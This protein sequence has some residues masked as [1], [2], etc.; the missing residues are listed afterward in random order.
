MIGRIWIAYRIE[1]IKALHLR[2]VYIGPIL[3]L[4]VV[5]CLPQLHPVARDGYSDY[6]F[7]ARAT[8]M[9]VSLLGL[10]LV[11]TFCAGLVSSEV[12]GGVI[13]S[14]LVRP[15]RRV[16]FLVAKYMLGVTYALLI[17]ISAAATSWAVVAVAGDVAG[18]TYGGE[19]L[20]TNQEMLRDYMLGFLVHLLPL[21]ATVAYAVMI[22]T[23][24][25]NSGVAVGTA[26]AVWAA[27]DATKYPLGIAPFLFTTYF[28]FPWRIFT[29]QARGLEASWQPEIFYCAAA[30]LGAAFLFTGT[31]AAMFNRRDMHL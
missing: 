14:V 10:L 19:V 20:F 4:G 24:S 17:S 1:L 3:V 30:S 21:T 11:M 27:V 16:E 29:E 9:T 6:G 13:R 12:S 25:R 8:S 28:E 2:F 31:A 23:F 18:V 7:I 15:I 5:L 26:V 22:S